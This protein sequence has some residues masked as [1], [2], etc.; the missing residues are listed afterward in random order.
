MEC[1]SLIRRALSEQRLELYAQQISPL[2]SCHQG[3]HYEV[4]V[5]IRNDE[6]EMVSP[7]LFMPAAERY[8]LAHRIDRYVV[9]A[10]IDWL[11]AHPAAVATL[12]MCAINLSGQSIGDHDFVH[13][14]QDKIRYSYYSG[15]ETVPGNYRNG[16]YR[17][18]ER[19]DP[20]VYLAQGAGVSDLPR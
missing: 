4:L 3:H 5:R 1:V 12:D 2:S 19:G 10:V 6:G 7:G 14:L 11:E 9:G 15:R 18:Y 13:F 8:N 17:Q 16:S 20:L